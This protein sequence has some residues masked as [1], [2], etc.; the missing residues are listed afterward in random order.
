MTVRELLVIL[1]CENLDHEVAFMLTPNHLVTISEVACLAS[2]GE[3]ATRDD[4]AVVCL[5]GAE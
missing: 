5:I 2:D 3:P 4:D 1:E